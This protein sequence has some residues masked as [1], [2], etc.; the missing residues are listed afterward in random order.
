MQLPLSPPFGSP[1]CQ[2]ENS[3]PG[4]AGSGMFVPSVHVQMPPVTVPPVQYAS[5]SLW[6]VAPMIAEAAAHSASFSAW[7]S[8]LTMFQPAPSATH[9]AI[10][11]GCESES[12]APLPPP[13]KP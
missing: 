10:A 13:Q 2:S 3:T 12:G 7:S 1:E 5:V 11:S 8:I 4:L 9:A 6:S